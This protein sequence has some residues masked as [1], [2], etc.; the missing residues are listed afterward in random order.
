MNNITHVLV[1]QEPELAGSYNFGRW[2]QCSKNLK[3]E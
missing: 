3:A 1:V 2:V